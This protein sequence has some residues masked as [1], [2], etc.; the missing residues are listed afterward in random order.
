MD[1]V[2][3][4]IGLSVFSNNFRPV[5]YAESCGMYSLFNYAI[6]HGVVVSHG[7]EHFVLIL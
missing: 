3:Q 5:Q 2:N 4:K 1:E 6:E 7:A